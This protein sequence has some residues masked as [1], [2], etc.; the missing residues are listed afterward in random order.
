MT[1]DAK[2]LS[3]NA[4]NSISQP[5][6]SLFQFAWVRIIY[7]DLPI[8]RNLIAIEN[9]SNRDLFLATPSQYVSALGDDGR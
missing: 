3:V 9:T 4:K 1:S 2:N 8:H 7:T 5:R 6:P